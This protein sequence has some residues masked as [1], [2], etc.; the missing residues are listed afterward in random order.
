MEEEKVFLTETEMLTL[1]LEAEKEKVRKLSEK[2]ILAENET[3]H[4]HKELLIERITNVSHRYKN[5][6]DINDKDR[7]KRK[8]FMSKLKEKYNIPDEEGLGYD[9]ISGELI[10]G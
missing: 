4:K 1:E 7:E 2:L 9:P 8:E 5:L 10:K 3:V 6:K